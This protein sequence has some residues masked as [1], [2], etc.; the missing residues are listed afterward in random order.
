MVQTFPSHVINTKKNSK[1]KTW[2]NICLEI[3]SNHF[4]MVLFIPLSRKKAKEIVLNLAKKFKFLKIAGCHS[5]TVKNIDKIRQE[6]RYKKQEFDLLRE[7][8]GY[9]VRT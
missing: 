1:R 8:T 9:W 6:I 5:K 7:Q 2:S 3:V 4:K